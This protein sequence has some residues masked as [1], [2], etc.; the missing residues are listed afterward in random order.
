MPSF[1]AR[2]SG[3]VDTGFSIRCRLCSSKTNIS[4]TVAF[5]YLIASPMLRPTRS[6]T[7]DFI[8]SKNGDVKQA[9]SPLDGSSNR[10]ARVKVTVSSEVVK[11]L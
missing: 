8:Q 3:A 6:Q 2:G 1:S 7:G 11:R 9:P 10:G 4:V 5:Y